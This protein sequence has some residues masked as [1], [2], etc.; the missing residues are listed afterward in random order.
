[1]H[2]R[3]FGT[4]EYIRVI[5]T[6][7]L[8]SFH[9]RSLKSFATSITFTFQICFC[10]STFITFDNDI[11]KNFRLR[12]LSSG[13]PPEKADG[14]FDVPDAEAQESYIFN[15]FGQ[16]VITKD[17]MTGIVKFKMAYTQTTST[18]KLASVTDAYGAKLTVLRDFKG[19][20]NALQTASGLKFS[21]QMSRVGDLEA[22]TSEN[23]PSKAV[24]R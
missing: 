9:G 21:L 3:L 5:K 16:H 20:V 4:L 8:Q 23:P 17:L 1:M 15:K 10:L 6:L 11:F 7:S 22:L 2:A 14:V 24:F 12:S 18:G 19:R 13:L